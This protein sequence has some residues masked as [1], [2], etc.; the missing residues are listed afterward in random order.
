MKIS[1]KIICCEYYLTF[2]RISEIPE[3]LK[4]LNANMFN[5][6]QFLSMSDMLTM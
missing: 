1:S 3:I 4:W 5:I 2:D 6:N